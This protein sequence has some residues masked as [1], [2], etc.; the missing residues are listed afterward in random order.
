LP[1]RNHHAEANVP[2]HKQHI[3]AINHAEGMK[4]QRT[5]GKRHRR[6]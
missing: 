6:H 3:V 4:Q 1:A 5:L 2:R